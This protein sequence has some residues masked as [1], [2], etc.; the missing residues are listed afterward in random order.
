[1]PDR[2]DATV[3][4]FHNWQTKQTLPQGAILLT[5]LEAAKKVLEQVE[6]PLGA[7]EITERAVDEGWLETEGATP[8]ATMRAQL[9]AALKRFGDG[10]EI[11]R[12]DRGIWG[13]REWQNE[14]DD[15][16]SEE[17]LQCPHPRRYWFL[18]TNAD[19]YD[20]EDL[21]RRETERWGTIISSNVSQKRIREEIHRGDRA[22][23]YRTQPHTDVWAEVEV[24]S[25][26]YPHGDGHVVDVTALRKLEPPVPLAAIRACDELGDLEFLGNTRLSV[27]H[28][29][30]EQYVAIDALVGEEVV[31][32]DNYSHDMIQWQLIS[33]GNSFGLDVWVASDCRGR[34]HEGEQFAEHTLGEL[35]N[36][37]FNDET[38]DLVRGIDVL[39]LRGNSIVAA[40]EIEHTTSIYSGLL[41][42][43]D[44]VALQPNINIDLY[45][46]AP[47]S[48]RSQ[49]ARQIG[50]PTFQ[51]L[52]RP[53]S[54]LCKFIAYDRL[55]E[56]AERV[57]DLSGF[58]RADLIRTVA[59][60]CG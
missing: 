23:V 43:S 36:V 37:G 9:G 28:L 35:P 46:V 27:S 11:V 57:E 13:L 32:R 20:V 30:P 24:V 16:S 10:A 14:D 58:L 18:T 31:T 4:V 50:R 3:K 41:R 19:L 45:I 5:F 17:E 12:V 44:L 48:R 2:S 34:S 60:D 52:P 47:P 51:R 40:F 25:E 7:T 54:G 53:L 8:A 59:E 39:W 21:F 1:V 29:T 55:S 38:V 22:F 26:P 49:M 6:K 15:R 42:L 56:L 33:L